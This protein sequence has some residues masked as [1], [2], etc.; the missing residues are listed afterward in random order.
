MGGSR[1]QAG[2]EEW[3]STTG[4]LHRC[5]REKEAHAVHMDPTKNEK[6]FSYMR[7]TNKSYARTRGKRD[8]L[9]PRR[10]RRN[11]LLLFF[12]LVINPMCFSSPY[13]P[14]NNNNNNKR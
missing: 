8:I 11:T 10:F 14:N 5:G 6:C 7:G 2:K 1:R 3:E 4:G 12:S 13:L 9:S